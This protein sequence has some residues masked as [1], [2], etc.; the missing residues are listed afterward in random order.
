MPS[1]GEDCGP[2]CDKT[3]LCTHFSWSL[4]N[5]GTCW[6]KT[7]PISKNDAFDSWDKGMV[8]GISTNPF[9]PNTGVRRGNLLWSDEFDNLNLNNWRQETGM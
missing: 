6:M 1:R 5:S 8:C 9:V 2:I 4:Y 3:A 7:G